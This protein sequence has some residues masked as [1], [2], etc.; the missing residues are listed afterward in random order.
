MTLIPPDR[1]EPEVS[2]VIVTHGAWPHTERALAAMTANTECAWELIVVDNRSKDETPERLAEF[3]DA[4]V[5]FNDQNRG[6]GPAV[7]QGAEHA[8]AK[9]LLL[10][11]TDAFVHPGWLEPLYEALQEPRVGAAIPRFLHPDGALQEAGGLLALDGSVVV[12]GDGDDPDRQCYRFRRI[13]DFGGAACMLVRR[14][15]FTALGGFDEAYAPAYY[16]DADFC[17]RPAQQ[18]YEVVYEPKST[19]THVRYGSSSPETAVRLSERNRRRFVKR[20]YQ[21]LIGRPWTFVGASGSPVIAARDAL[22]TP[23]LLICGGTGDPDARALALAVQR[24][25]PRARVTWANAVR[26]GDPAGPASG[27]EAAIEFVDC[28]DP[29]WL[30]DRLFHYDMAVV[31]ADA[32]PK[33]RNRLE[34]TQPQAPRIALQLLAGD[35]DAMIS[36]VRLTLAAAG[37][38]PQ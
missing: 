13:V 26:P 6:F 34:H 17:L 25:W 23:R 2:V 18:G 38:A 30:D 8:R 16:E 15:L 29:A 37:I 28:A 7:N 22:A 33:L 3:R 24:G 31:A 10:L 19:V 9:H 5:I 36:R 14:A 27:P 35:Q 1:G 12:Y 21:R 20:W 11:N 4:R 32:T